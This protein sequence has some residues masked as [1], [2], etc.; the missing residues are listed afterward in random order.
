M[1]GGN[2]NDLQAVLALARAGR[3]SSAAAAAGVDATTLGRRVR[4][5]EARLGVTLFENTRQGQVLTEHGER[6]VAEIEAMETAALRIVEGDRARGRVAG[7][8]R[9]SVAEGFG[10]WLVARHLE[11]F[12]AAHP[13]LAIDLVASSGFLNPSKRETDIAVTLSRPA[14]GP[15]IAGKLTDYALRIYASRGY[16]AAHP[17]VA[18]PADLAGGA[19]RLVGYV[20]D[21]IYAPELRYLSEIMPGLAADLRCPSIVTQ[22]AAIAGSAGLGVLPCFIGESDP[23]LVAV[24]PERTIVR[25]FWLV[26]HRDTHNLARIRAFKAWLENLVRVHHA[27]LVPPRAA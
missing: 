15:L 27:Q 16:V 22:H 21:M 25:S 18:R 8:L 10:T 7:H 17:G 20:P 3:L 11:S 4:R 19:H 2:W 23:G 26:T 6:A 9:V 1:Q 14:A 5:L 12:T 24:L 13:D